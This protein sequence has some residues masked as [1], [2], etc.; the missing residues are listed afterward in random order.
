M[1]LRRSTGRS[2]R[3]SSPT[4]GELSRLLA[5]NALTK[6]LNVAVPAAVLAASLLLGATWLT[7]VALVCWLAL[8]A[9]TFFDAREARFVG[10]RAREE[11][12]APPA[13]VTERPAFAEEIDRRVRAAVSAR[14]AIRAAIEES[15]VPHDNVT[16]EVDALLHAMQADALRAQRIHEFLTEVPREQLDPRTLERV[17][18]RLDRLVEELDR[19]V[20]TLQTVRAEVLVT[21]GLA[22]HGELSARL[23][24]LRINVQLVSA[25]LED[26]FAGVKRDTKG[27]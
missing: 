19:I 1:T 4:R 11:R 5:I 13:L 10:E 15:D 24:E 17:R 9:G 2:A 16:E 3:S 20:G 18:G 8:V 6:P 25:G 7:I 21:D 27:V 14:A 23:S 12:R 26:A 22:A